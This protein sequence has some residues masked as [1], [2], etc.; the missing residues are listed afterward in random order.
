M[1]IL[2]HRL[3][4]ARSYASLALSRN[5]RRKLRRK[6]KTTMMTT[7][8]HDGNH[9]ELSFFRVAICQFT[10][11]NWA[12]FSVHSLCLS[13]RHHHH[14]FHTC[15]MCVQFQ[16]SPIFRSAHRAFPLNESLSKREQNKRQ[17]EHIIL[18]H[19]HVA[20]SPCLTHSQ[21]SKT[22]ILPALYVYFAYFQIAFS[23]NGQSE[24]ETAERV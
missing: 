8:K 4:V 7:T 3:L 14:T 5:A 1:L 23:C 17:Y 11:K 19:R 6:E 20:P 10:L 24:T 22:K 18:T 9:Y 12:S 13:S 15:P 2:A 21:C 16:D